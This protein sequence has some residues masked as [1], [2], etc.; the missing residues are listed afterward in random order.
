MDI[1]YC[2]CGHGFLSVRNAKIYQI[3][4]IKY[5]QIIIWLLL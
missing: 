2:P 5:V 4:C 3:V 1:Y